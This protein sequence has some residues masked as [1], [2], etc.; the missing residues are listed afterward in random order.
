MP[1]RD[2][3]SQA[4][5]ALL[6]VVWLLALFTV[7]A[8]EFIA[9]G[10]VKA[11][12]EHNKRDDLRALALALAG[13]RAAVAAL[14]AQIDGF[15]LDEDGTLLVRYKG[16]EDGV[17]AAAADVPLGEGTYS[18]SVRDEDGLVTF[19]NVPVRARL[20]AAQASEPSR[21]ARGVIQPGGMREG[22]FQ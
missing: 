12:A 22:V 2:G 4:G 20:G 16:R 7:V 14:D 3:R 15:E 13:Y 6:L 21:M 1:S 8:A 9:S 17:A 19:T 11:A 10:R 18:W 5:I